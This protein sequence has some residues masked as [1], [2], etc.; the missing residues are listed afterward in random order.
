MIESNKRRYIGPH[1]EFLSVQLAIRSRVCRKSAR[2]RRRAAP[3]RT[4]CAPLNARSSFRKWAAVEEKSPGSA[5]CR[6]STELGTRLFGGTSRFTGI[7]P[8]DR[9]CSFPGEARVSGRTSA[10]WPAALDPARAMSSPGEPLATARPLVQRC[11]IVTRDGSGYG[12]TVCDCN[13]VR[14]QSVNE[15]HFSSVL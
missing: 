15:G 9:R 2:R 4:T 11:V 5:S 6:R 7:C 3:I 13:P 1:W 8:L 10:K 12:L 14:V